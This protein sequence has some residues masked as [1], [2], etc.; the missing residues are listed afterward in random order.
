MPAFQ[1]RLSDAQI[2]AVAQYVAQNAGKAGG[3]G[4]GGGG[5]P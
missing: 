4:G 5:G 2:K 1:G 3:G